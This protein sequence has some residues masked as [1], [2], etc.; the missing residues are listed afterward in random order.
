MD[1]II[2][3][4]G[5]LNGIEFIIPGDQTQEKLI[6]VIC[7]SEVN[8]AN[9]LIAKKNVLN[10]G[11][12]DQIQTEL[13][14]D[15]ADTKIA[16]TILPNET[17]DFS[18]DK[19]YFG[20]DS[21]DLTNPDKTI[22]LKSGEVGVNQVQPNPFNGIDLP[23]AAKRL[24]A[25]LADNFENGQFIQVLK[26]TPGVATF[27]GSYCVFGMMLIDTDGNLTI[28]DHVELDNNLTIDEHGDITLLD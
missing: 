18:D 21:I 3:K 14:N 10:G 26:P 8:N 13:I 9:Q 27:Q 19:K 11:N 23:E 28:D 17:A 24:I 1:Y 5:K 4:R 25:V 20:I 22:S 2:I 12:D 15:G 7:D 6:F 16:I